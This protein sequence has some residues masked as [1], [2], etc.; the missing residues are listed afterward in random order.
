MAQNNSA[1]LRWTMSTIS[2]PVQYSTGKA[3][4]PELKY[5]NSNMHKNALSLSFPILASSLS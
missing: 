5:V 3:V 1:E 2:S 4:I